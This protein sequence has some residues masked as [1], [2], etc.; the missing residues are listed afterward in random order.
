MDR[1]NFIDWK[2]ISATELLLGMETVELN[3]K[4]DLK[5]IIYQLEKK[6]FVRNAVLLKKYGSIDREEYIKSLAN[7]KWE[8]EVKDVLGNEVYSLLPNA[9]RELRHS[10]NYHVGGYDIDKKVN[11]NFELYWS[12]IF[13]GFWEDPLKKLSQKLAVEFE[14]NPSPKNEL[15]V[16]LESTKIDINELS[17]IERKLSNISKLHKESEY[18]IFNEVKDYVSKDESA[19]LDIYGSLDNSDTINR[20]EL[21]KQ[22]KKSIKSITSIF[23]LTIGIA[24]M[25]GG[26]ANW[27]KT[28]TTERHVKELNKKI[29]ILTDKEIESFDSLNKEECGEIVENLRDKAKIILSDG[30]E[31]TKT[32]NK[33][34]ANK[35]NR[36]ISE[37]KETIK[38]VLSGEYPWRRNH[39]LLNGT[40]SVN[41][42]EDLIRTSLREKQEVVEDF[43]GDVMEL[44][45][46]KVGIE[47]ILDGGPT[48]D[49]T[50]NHLS[51]V[52]NDYHF[53]NIKYS[54]ETIKKLKQISKKFNKDFE[55]LRS[56]DLSDLAVSS[57]LKKKSLTYFMEELPKNPLDVTFGNDSG[58]CVF[59]SKKARE[60]Q[61]GFAVPFYINNP[62]VRLFGIYR[63]QNGDKKKR[64]GLVLG[65]E[66]CKIKPIPDKYHGGVLI[67]NSNKILSC[68]S[69][70]ISPLGFAGGKDTVNKLVDYAEDWL[71]EYGKMNG[72]DGVTMGNHS[73]NT[74]KN[75]SKNSGDVVNNPLFFMGPTNVP[76]ADIFSMYKDG[77]SRLLF[78]HDELNEKFNQKSLSK[79]FHSLNSHQ[80]NN[81]IYSLNP[82]ASE[83]LNTE[84]PLIESIRT[85]GLGTTRNSNYWLYKKEN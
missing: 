82:K 22:I 53:P 48:T 44:S 69:L 79:T 62:N 68:N 4:K 33:Y 63:K 47:Q 60:M 25:G 21:R 19:L 45:R 58:C 41:N 43:E 73:Y 6:G 29:G 61:N 13:Q 32:M 1:N 56:I 76:Y 24:E 57:K 65:F 67:P 34:I 66:T 49:Y 20:K 83:D 71:I 15:E 31:L 77:F 54:K 70:E 7:P 8:K 27:Y 42:L 81:F 75:Y 39:S 17:K 10:N 28:K 12:R 55:Y 38:I 26:T 16:I 50:Q 51:T 35:D 37:G 2:K 64:M 74:S 5:K 3:Q 18:L 30:K 52:Q 78:K 84:E 9:Y 23:D 40:Y 14:L 11:E 72:Y 46:L 59:V 80:R 36:I 85:Q